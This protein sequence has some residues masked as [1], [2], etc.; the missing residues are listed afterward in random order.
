MT[1]EKN[2]LKKMGDNYVLCKNVVLEIVSF[3]VFTIIFHWKIYVFF[4]QKELPNSWIF[5]PWKIP[6]YIINLT[7]SGPVEKILWLSRANMDSLTKYM[8]EQ[9]SLFW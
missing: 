4:S 7:L 2:V 3:C 6:G 9:I 1:R 5:V 8:S